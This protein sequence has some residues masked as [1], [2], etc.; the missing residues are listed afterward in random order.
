M[1]LQRLIILREIIRFHV[2]LLALA[3]ICMAWSVVAFPMQFI[4]PK[5]WKRPVGRHGITIGFRLYL[6]LLSTFGMGRFDLTELDSLRNEESLI[7]APN[8]PSLLDAVMVLSR[9]PNVACIMKAVIVDNFFMG[10]GARLAQYIRNDSMRS[11]FHLA[12]QELGTGSH[13]LLFPEGTRTVR[14]PVNPIQGTTGLIAK[15]AQVPVQ[16]VFI[17][18]NSGFLGK[19]WSL[20]RRPPMPVLYKIRLGKRFPAPDNVQQFNQ[21]LDA[22]FTEQLA[23]A[24]L[25][26]YPVTP[27]SH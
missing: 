21:E 10:T 3:I 2:S 5:A 15:R 8:H 24:M 11:M 6:F 23:H 7:L 13:L 20:F 12:V 14:N 19:G 1:L 25:P 4:L 16:T 17:E 27:H 9:L 18:T 26:D 22:Y